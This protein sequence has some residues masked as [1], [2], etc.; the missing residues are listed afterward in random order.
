M[1]RR[2][3]D[4]SK[5]YRG[6]LEMYRKVSEMYQKVS[7]TCREVSRY[8]GAYRRPNPLVKVNKIIRYATWR[9]GYTPTL[10]Q[11]H[12]RIGRV[13]DTYSMS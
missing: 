3:K 8:I 5:T 2:R 11:T 1:Y 13:S 12:P 7:E 9:I 10:Y 6:V 4:V